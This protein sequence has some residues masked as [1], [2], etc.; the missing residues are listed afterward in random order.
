MD[1]WSRNKIYIYLLMIIITSSFPSSFLVVFLFVLFLGPDLTLCFMSE[2]LIIIALDLEELLEV[3][4][5]I[6]RSMV[7]R[8][9]VHPAIYN[10]NPN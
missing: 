8:E 10:I 3:V 5:A 1:V 2:A 7:E 4:L 9:R 6:K